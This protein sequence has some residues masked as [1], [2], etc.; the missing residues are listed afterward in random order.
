M[1]TPCICDT[2]GQAQKNSHVWLKELVSTLEGP[3]HDWLLADAVDARGR[4]LGPS[5]L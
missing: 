4:D 3:D 5:K 1:G 2:S